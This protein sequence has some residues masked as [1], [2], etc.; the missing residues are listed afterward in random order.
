M[1]KDTIC[2]RYAALAWRLNRLHAGTIRSLR[3]FDFVKCHQM[4]IRTTRDQMV[5]E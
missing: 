1:H 4:F 5:S 3:G 2:R